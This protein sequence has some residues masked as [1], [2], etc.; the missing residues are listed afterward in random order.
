VHE[1][2]LLIPGPT[3]LPP[4]VLQAMGQQMTNHRG[5]T[6]GRIMAE[7]LEGLKGIFQTRNDIIPLVCSGTG[8]LEA[9][10]VNFLSPGDRV[11]SVNNGA[12]CERFAEIAERFGVRVDRVRAEWGRPVPPAAIAER[13]RADAGREYR[14]VLVTQS[15]TSTG[16]RNDVAAVRSILGDHPALLMVDGV[17]SVGAIPLAT[18]EWGVDVVVTGSQKALMSPPGMAFVSVSDRGWAAAEHASI[19]RFYLDLRRGRSEAHRP[20]P[21]T[22]FTAAV[23]VAYAVHEAVRMIQEEGLERVFERHR[24]MARMVRAGVRGMG[25]RT[26]AEDAYAVDTVTAIRTPEGMD[27]APVLSRAREHYGVLFG[28][29]IGR[30]EHTVIRFGHLGFTQPELLLQGLEVLGRALTDLD[31]PVPAEAGL[32]A[33]RATLEDA[34]AGDPPPDVAWRGVR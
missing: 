23:T 14:A 19:P 7:M 34:R 33:A 8:G 12:F 30:L 26:L 25:L 20:L 21:S 11:L 5:P 9:A 15:E 28:R 16:V 29:G 10:I 32:A 18:D 6:F 13:L 31:H 27:A 1:S 3:P 22:A 17:S 24:R 2:N 4:R